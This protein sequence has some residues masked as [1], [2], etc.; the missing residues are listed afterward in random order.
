MNRKEQRGANAK[1]RQSKVVP[2]QKLQATIQQVG[3]AHNSLAQAFNQNTKAFLESM[4]YVD[5]MLWVL[6]T[7]TNDM[8]NSCLATVVEGEVRQ[9]D[10][11][12]YL[13]RY[14]EHLKVKPAPVLVNGD[15]HEQP[16][17]FGGES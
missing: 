2:L 4:K 9:V 13:R 5:A 17:V 15:A 7:A 6:R 3:N 1:A 10:I 12:S 8:L 11:P 16:V 14:E